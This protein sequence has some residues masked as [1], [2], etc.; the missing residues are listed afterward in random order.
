MPAPVALVTGTSTPGTCRP[1]LL[2]ARSPIIGGHA[3]GPACP[4]G[5]GFDRGASPRPG[6]EVGRLSW[7]PRGSAWPRAADLCRR[8]PQQSAA[9]RR[10]PRP[11]ACGNAGSR[12]TPIR[13]A[14]SPLPPRRGPEPPAPAPGAARTRATPART[15]PVAAQVTDRRADRVIGAASSQH[16]SGKLTAS[17]DIGRCAGHCPASSR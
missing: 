10:R 12:S 9:P 6:G 15:P 7:H 17:R 8:Q 13:S 5:D 1:T 3:E 14:E 16:L 11:R 2:A 4:N